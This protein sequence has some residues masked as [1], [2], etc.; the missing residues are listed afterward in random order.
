MT[1]AHRSREYMLVCQKK[2]KPKERNGLPQPCY[3]TPTRLS[4][5]V[6]G[7][8]SESLSRSPSAGSSSWRLR[9]CPQK[10]L[11]D[12]PFLLLCSPSSSLFSLRERIAR[13]L[14][15]YGEVHDEHVLLF[16]SA[17]GIDFA[18]V[19]DSPIGDLITNGERI[20]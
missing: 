19:E 8:Q 15:K 9:I 16:I 1:I 10:P 3:I 11:H 20:E 5:A 4:Y 7:M 18:L 13:V 2:K 17:E 12:V 6:R 14:R